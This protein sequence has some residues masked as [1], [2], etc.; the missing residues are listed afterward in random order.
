MGRE[1]EIFIG[2][3]RTHGAILLTLFGDGVDDGRREAQC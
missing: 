2:R 1:M 3:M